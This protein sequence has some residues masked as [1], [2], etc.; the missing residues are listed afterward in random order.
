MLV[1]PLLAIMAWFAVDYFVSERAQPAQ[2][3]STYPL[4]ARS[5]CRYESGRCDLENED[6]GVSLRPVAIDATGVSVE[7]TSEHPLTRAMVGLVEGGNALT[8]VSLAAGNSD[9]TAWTGRIA[10]PSGQDSQLRIA[11]VVSGS[12]FFAEVPVIFLVIKP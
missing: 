9:R 10:T 2:A 5:N 12:T 8:P 11:V 4:V 6:F 7:L 1:A 3:G